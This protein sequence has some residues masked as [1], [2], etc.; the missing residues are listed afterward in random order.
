[1]RV[2][3]AVVVALSLLYS[4]PSALAADVQARHGI[5]MHGEP[6]YGPDAKH[7]DYADPNAPKGGTIR[8]AAIGSFD[9]FNPYILKG[10]AAAGLNGVFE[11]LMEGSSDE[12]FTEYGLLAESVEVPTDRSW[13]TFTLRKEARWHDGKPVTVADVIFSLNI[14][15]TKGHPFY[16]SYFHNLERAEEVGERKVKFYF[17]GGENRELPLITG[18]LP[19]LA[20]HYWEKR[21]FE[22]TTLEPPI[23]SGPYKIKAFESGRSIVY[24]RDPNYWGKDI[25]LGKGKD[26]FGTIRYDYYRDQTV[27]LEAFKAGEYDFRIENNSKEWATAYKVPAVQEGLIKLEEIPHQ[28]PTGMQAFVFN[29]RKPIFKDPRVRRALTY[30][31]DFEWTNKNLFYGQYVRTRSYFSNSELAA[32][33]LPG[34]AELKLLEPYRGRIP[35]EVFTKEYRPP[36]TPDQDAYRANLRIALGLLRDAG[37]TF[38][39]RKLVDAKTGQPFE[40][41]FLLVQPAFERVVLPYVRNLER[42]GVQVRVR[43]VDPAQY[44]KRTEQFDFDMIVD[45]FGQSLSPGNE[46]RDFWGSAAAGQNGSRNTIGIKNPVIDE[47]IDKIIA[48]PSREELIARCRALDRVLQWGHY[49]VPNWHIR[50]S[51]VAYWDKFGRPKITPKYGLCVE[52]WWIDPAKAEALAGKRNRK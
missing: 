49:V 43:T 20:K 17:S 39:D 1:M 18:Q 21:D 3:A 50:S 45:S 31:F 2:L 38:K 14:L 52:C 40:F 26:N 28:R 36:S 44:Q 22:K 13:V 19:V 29:T 41:E 42:L 16:R 9:N 30:A 6:K 11:T 47:L 5:A 10:Q 24:E 37:W 7:F 46:Q 25:L 51:R 23:G 27:S 8:Y 15:K 34:P 48:A 35:D 12:A 4:I 32:S 33:G